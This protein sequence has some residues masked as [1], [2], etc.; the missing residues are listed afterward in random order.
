[1][2]DRGSHEVVWMRA[3]SEITG[4]RLR[5]EV[6]TLAGL[7]RA[8]GIRSNNTVALQG[9]SSFT[10]LWSIFALWSIGAQVLLFE[11]RLDQAERMELLDRCA[12]QFL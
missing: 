12:P 7:L 9:T 11:P 8:H 1:V 4:E 3:A 6:D 10:L 5:T 2:L